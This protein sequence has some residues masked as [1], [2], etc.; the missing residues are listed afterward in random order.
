MRGEFVW[1]HSPLSL[2]TIASNGTGTIVQGVDLKGYSAYSEAWVWLM[3]DDRI[4]GDQQGLE[5]FLR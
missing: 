5:P 3:G 4:I 1:K 2:E